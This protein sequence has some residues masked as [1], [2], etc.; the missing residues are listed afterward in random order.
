VYTP[1]LN[2]P[3]AT[4]LSAKV[5]WLHPLSPSQ[6]NFNG[7]HMMRVQCA[8]TSP[9]IDSTGAIV[10]DLTG[11]GTLWT[12]GC[13]AFQFGSPN[14]QLRC[15]MQIEPSSGNR[16]RMIIRVLPGSAAAFTA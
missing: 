1:N 3:G 10:I 9:V 15:S 4:S 16:A 5:G 2:Q 11:H 12:Q 7:L 6:T 8:A 14:A 13:S